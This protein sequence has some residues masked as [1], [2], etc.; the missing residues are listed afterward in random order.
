ME[1]ILRSFGAVIDDVD[2]DD[3]TIVAKIST[4]EVDRYRT[5][6]K[7]SGVDFTNY[8]KNP[9]VLFEHGKSPVRGSVPIGRNLW[10]KQDGVGNGRILA[11][12][13]FAKDE[14]SDLLFS[15]YKDETMRGWSVS[16]LPSDAGTPTREEVRSRPELKDCELVYRTSELL[17]YSCVSIP[18]TAGALTDPELRSLSKLV[19]RGFWAPPEDVK[20]LVEPIVEEMNGGEPEPVEDTPDEPDEKS[21]DRSADEAVE[22][23]ADEPIA[24]VVTEEI[25]A[26]PIDEVVQ[27]DADAVVET[28]AEPEA[29]V[30]QAEPEPEPEPVDPLAGLPPIVARRLA[31]IMAD[32][33]RMIKDW[34]EQNRVMIRELVELLRGKA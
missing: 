34:H 10:V 22:V 30:V 32:N 21:V 4:G 7:S 1:N 17:E 24:D 25:P 13:Q 6:I 15:F 12:T 19:V 11:K 8:R 23:V 28:P 31:D 20:P 5:V 3:R 14:F 16:I 27:R 18:G 26:D 33:S 9:I 29:T 2:A